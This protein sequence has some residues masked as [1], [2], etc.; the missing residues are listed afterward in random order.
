MDI[1]MTRLE[2]II[3]VDTAAIQLEQVAAA[4]DNMGADLSLVHRVQ[5]LVRQ[6]DDLRVDINQCD[7]LSEVE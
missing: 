7:L 5:N 6:L 1:T 3:T 4:L 2:T